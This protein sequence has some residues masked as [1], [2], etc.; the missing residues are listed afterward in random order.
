[1]AAA[2]SPRDRLCTLMA[3][4]ATWFAGAGMGADSHGLYNNPT[5]GLYD[6]AGLAR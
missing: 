3:D 6:A 4:S 5:A 1:M 2:G